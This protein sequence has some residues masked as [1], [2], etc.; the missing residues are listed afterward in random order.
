LN[1]L[2]AVKAGIAFP[3]LKGKIP[4]GQPTPKRDLGLQ[5]CDLVGARSYDEIVATPDTKL[6]NRDL[7]LCGKVFRVSACVDRFVDK[8][9]GKPRRMKTPAVVQAASIFVSPV[10]AGVRRVSSN[11]HERQTFLRMCVS[12]RTAELTGSPDQ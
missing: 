7:W 4:E 8:K 1:G 9:A 3:R 5:T 11:S 10:D 12:A 6:S 2:Q